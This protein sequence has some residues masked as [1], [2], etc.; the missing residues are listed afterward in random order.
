MS[1][2]RNIAL[3]VQELEDGEF[4]WVL[5]EATDYSIADA[6]PYLPIEKVTTES[7]S[8][9]PGMEAAVE[10][11][12]QKIAE[13]A[14][15]GYFTEEFDWRAPMDTGQKWIDGMDSLDM[16]QVASQ[17]TV[18]V[19]LINGS[20]D[21]VVPP[22]NAEDLHSWIPSSQLL[23]IDGADHT[24]NIFSGDMTAFNNLTAATATFF[25]DNLK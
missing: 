9:L 8:V 16:E 22:A 21:D 25:A 19:L 18:P 23:L 6:L 13:A 5:M 14:E 3:T 11:N 12:A 20:K 17:I 15:K 2:L 7:L 4:Y 24:F 10:G 1:Q